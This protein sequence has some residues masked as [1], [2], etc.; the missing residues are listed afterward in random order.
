MLRPRRFTWVLVPTT[1][2]IRPGARTFGATWGDPWPP[3][4]EWEPPP[5]VAR[6][7][8]H[9]W[10]GQPLSRARTEK[11]I[12]HAV[13]D[14]LCARLIPTAAWLMIWP[15]RRSTFFTSSSCKA[16]TQKNEQQNKYTRARAPAGSNFNSQIFVFF[17][18]RAR[19]YC[20]AWF[21]GLLS[22]GQH[23]PVVRRHVASQSRKPRLIGAL[24]SILGVFQLF[25][26]TQLSHWC[27][28]MN[29]MVCTPDSLVPLFSRSICLALRSHKLLFKRSFY[30]RMLGNYFYCLGTPVITSVSIIYEL[31]R[32]DI[33]LVEA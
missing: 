5:I 2:S 33:W 18:L 32:A 13:C 8:A 19:G 12:S 15:A 9:C 21:C 31:M 24:H 17:S 30:A 10:P 25:S 27:E 7:K 28:W 11:I 23:R 14:T 29:E 1:P 16:N 26:R 22:R 20:S 6:W 4:V 3:E